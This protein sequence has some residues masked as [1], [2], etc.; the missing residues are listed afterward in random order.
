VAYQIFFRPQ[1]I[2][3]T[4]GNHSPGKPKKV[5]EFQ[6][7]QE[8]WKKSGEVKSGVFFQAL[9]T[10]KNC[11]LTGVLPRT[12]LGKLTTLPRWSLRRSPDSPVGW[13][14]GTPHPL[15][16]AVTTPTVT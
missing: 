5:R 10:P 7:G 2:C 16:Q 11:F 12:L 8:K 13:G 15:T 14:G 3:S 4:Q 6:S 9:N 1:N